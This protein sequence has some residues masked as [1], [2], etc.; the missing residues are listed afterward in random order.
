MYLLPEVSSKLIGPDK[1]NH[2]TVESKH[3]DTWVA[4]LVK[5]LTLDLSSGLDLRVGSSRP[6]LGSSLGMEPTLKKK[7][8][9]VSTEANIQ[10]MIT[11][12]WYRL[13]N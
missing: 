1:I 9:R 8:K 13:Y 2:G 3:R 7:E 4:Q 12:S 10:K 11:N 6:V 5:H